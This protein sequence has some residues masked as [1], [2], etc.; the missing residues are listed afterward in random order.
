MNLGSIAGARHS[1]GAWSTQTE[2][3]ELG[4]E[5]VLATRGT[6]R[7]HSVLRRTSGDDPHRARRQD[8]PA[9]CGPTLRRRRPCRGR[10]YA[11]HSRVGSGRSGGSRAREGRARAAGPRPRERHRGRGARRS[12][13]SEARD[14]SHRARNSRCRRRGRR[15]SPP[16]GG[17][18]DPGAVGRAGVGATGGQ[19]RGDDSSARDRRRRS[20]RAGA[21]THRGRSTWISERWPDT[22]RTS[23]S[24]AERSPTRS[25]CVASTTRRTMPPVRE[26]C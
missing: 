25:S 9:G 24:A 13:A 10:G 23:S 21:S 14:R 16:R 7:P 20:H 11:A 5:A 2:R 3:R 15:P 22:R 4:G 26:T 18:D 6:T 8:D 19:R 1:L 12:G 17:L